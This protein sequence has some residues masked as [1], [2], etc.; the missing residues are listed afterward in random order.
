MRLF[1]K[2]IP[3]VSREVI[4][5]LMSDKDI[6]VEATR[7]NDAELDLAAIMREYLTQEEKVN[8]ATR[9][10]LERRGYDHS[11]FAQV[12]R[13]MADVRGF[14]MGDEGI[15]DVINQM[16]EFLLISRNVEEVFSADNVMRMKIFEV[17]KKH[18][19]VDD[20]I[21]REARSRL[22]HL[23]EGTSAFEIEYQKTVEQIR[24]ARGL[25]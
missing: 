15:E 10:A 5:R 19:D 21:D 18:L 9:E 7:I 14:K 25:I 16:L 6:E 8:Q 3:I 11:K 24:R 12:K 23:Q 17:M 4:A 1:P 22:K 13:E 2:V 20:D